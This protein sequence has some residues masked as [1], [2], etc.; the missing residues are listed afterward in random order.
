M[1]RAWLIVLAL[2][3]LAPLVRAG[4]AG[5]ASEAAAAF[6]SLYGADVRRAKATPS[7]KDDIDLA[8]RILATA[9]KAAN[10]PE[11]LSILCENACDLGLVH[12]D[13][14]ATAIEAMQLEAATV[15]ARAGLCADRIVDIRQR[16]FDAAKGD[17][18]PAAGESLIDAILAALEARK[19]AGPPPDE[20]AAYKRALAV[21][22][23]VKSDRAAALD[24]HIKSLQDF[25]RVGIEIEGLKKQLAA[26]PQNQTV[27]QRLVRLHLVDLND[28]AEAEKYVEGVQ[29]AA[30]LKFVPAAAK[31]VESVPEMACLQLG[32]WYL[33]LAETASASVKPLMFGRA[34]EYYERF[35]QL[36]AVEDLDRTRA[37]AAVQKV[38][39]ELQKSGQPSV[40]AKVP[41]SGKEID[42]LALVD[43]AQDT[44]KGKWERRGGGVASVGEAPG[45]SRFVVPMAIRGNYELQ[46]TFVRTSGSDMVGLVVPV[47]PTSVLV[48][49]SALYGKVSGLSRINDKGSNENETTVRPGNLENGRLY[50]LAVKVAL[51][52]DNVSIDV[53]L[54][55]R[56]YINWKGAVGA[57]TPSPSW[58]IPAAGAIG[59][60][61]SNCKVEFRSARLRMLSGEAKPVRL[62]EQRSG[63]TPLIFSR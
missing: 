33:A 55:G 18:R 12:A 15:P 34:K 9:G 56:P 44:I 57:L 53:Q 46:V 24:A 13:G 19:K 32:D 42:L 22:R 8:A 11:F 41:T 23:A 1:G 4:D 37:A 2:A 27:R 39:A 31:P 30:L 14:Y 29:D 10:Q 28:P 20:A 40:P 7:A 5:N 25:I 16:Q 54:D 49:L 45:E 17:A 52:A 36:H 47:G 58:R 3:A 63:A 21:A 50:A 59:V 61:A 43:P 6:E 51:E 38:D 62:P 48:A 26:D 35:V 60:G